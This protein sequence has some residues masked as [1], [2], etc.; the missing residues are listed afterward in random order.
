[1]TVLWILLI[2]FTMLLIRVPVAFALGSIGLGMLVVGGFS[3]LMAPQAMLSTLDGFIL[4]AVPLFLLMSNVLLKGGVGQDLFAAVQAWVGHWPG[5]LAVATI[6]SCGV[7]AAISGSSVATAATIGTVAIPEMISRGYDKRF[8]YGLLAAGGTLG[9]LIPPSIPMIVYG[10]VTEES[11]I[12]LFLAGVGPGLLL[13]TLFIGF[14]MIYARY[15]GGF[16]DQEKASSSVRKQASIRALPSVALAVIIIGG[17]YAGVFTPTEAAAIGFTAALIITALLLRTLTWQGFK[18]ACID[19]MATTVAILLIIGGAKIFGKAIALY[20]IPQDISAFIS[21][22]ID[23]PL[24]FILVV[25]VVLLLMGLVFETLSMVLIMTPVLLP[26][27]M[28]MGFDPI[29][30]GIYMVIMVE[31]ALITPPVGLNLYVIQSVA[32]VPLS[33]VARGVLMFLWLMFVTVAVLYV[34]PDLALYIPFKL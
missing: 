22:N 5:G 27:A 29:W 6:I 15:W 2:L 26:A 30:F 12:S 13:I 1:M 18:E 25:T 34:W 23:T 19:S 3:P 16:T 33:E 28:H 31:C 10:F 9:I 14:S 8:V 17:I 21:Q 24:V 7:F 20:R 32:K 4:L 11:V